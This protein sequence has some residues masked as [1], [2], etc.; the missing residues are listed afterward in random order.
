M[1]RRRRSVE[2]AKSGEPEPAEQSTVSEPPADMT[3]GPPNDALDALYRDCAPMMRSLARR[4][5]GI[6]IPEAESLV[7]DVFA[8]YLVN[9]SRVRDAKAYLIGGICNASRQYLRENRAVEGREIEEC[10]SADV[11]AETTERVSKHLML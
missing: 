4:R 8:T 6:P 7:H 10:S 3:K 11:I 9:P 2:R 1:N 5:F